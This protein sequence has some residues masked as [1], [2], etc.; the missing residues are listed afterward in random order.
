VLSHR[1]GFDVWGK[2]V[3][4]RTFGEKH[5]REPLAWNAAAIKAGERRR[6]FSS[7]MTDNFLNDKTIDAERE[8]LWPLIAATPALDWLLLTKHPER[9]KSTLPNIIPANV[10]L[11]VSVEDNSAAWRVDAL[12]GVDAPVRF[13]S[14]EP[15]LGPIDKV[16]LTGIDWVIV[17]G[18]SGPRCRPM[19]P[20]WAEDVRE[21]LRA[22]IDRARYVNAQIPCWETRLS[23]GLLSLVVWLYEARAARVHGWPWPSIRQAVEM[24]SCATCGHVRCPGRSAHE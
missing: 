19:D 1:Y 17:G 14:V 20:A 11:G 8:K 9:F 15:M 16:S 21:V 5:W 7:S 10:W 3:P 22:C 2:D 23:I 6:V 12:R 18:E 13:L 4:R 24:E